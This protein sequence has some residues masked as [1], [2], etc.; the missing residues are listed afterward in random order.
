MTL[1]TSA[2]VYW[3]GVR[4]K[5]VEFDGESL[6]ISNYLK[7]IVV[8]IQDVESV[9]ERGLDTWTL[10]T[11]TFGSTTEFGRRVVF[12]PT[13]RWVNRWAPHPVV[14]ELLAAATRARRRA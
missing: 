3:F 7:E 2:F 14:D 9:S 8:P 1:A 12:R 4:L 5:R 13:Q 11:L 10:V 6:F